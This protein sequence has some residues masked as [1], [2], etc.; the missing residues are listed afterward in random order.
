MI[1]QNSNKLSAPDNIRSRVVQLQSGLATARAFGPPV[2]PPFIQPNTIPAAPPRILK[3]YLA[4][5]YLFRKHYKRS[6][7]SGKI[8]AYS[9]EEK[10]YAVNALQHMS[11]QGG[12]CLVIGGSVFWTPPALG[13]FKPIRH[14]I[15]VFYDGQLLLEYDKRNDCGEL[16]D[17][18]LSRG[19]KFMPGARLGAFAVDGLNC[20][21][22]TCVDHGLGQLK[23]DAVRNLDLQFIVSNT[24]TVKPAFIVAK[25]QGYVLH[26]NAIVGGAAIYRYP[27]D[28]GTRI[29]GPPLCWGD[30]HGSNA[31][32]DLP[33]PANG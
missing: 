24:V 10:D 33:W 18:E 14:T 7:G 13:N 6:E 23:N 4:P 19:Y 9:Q 5:E 8:T 2:P 20:G 21:I 29:L 16:W 28:A 22:E 27:F 17:F 12:G 26:C 11:R 25:R 3:I 15:Y 1:T 31:F 32:F 30:V